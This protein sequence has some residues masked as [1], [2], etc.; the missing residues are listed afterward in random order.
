MNELEKHRIN[1]DA[2]R[3]TTT[4]R[5]LVPSHN[6]IRRYASAM[7]YR[8]RRRQADSPRR[9]RAGTKSSTGQQ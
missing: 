4:S 9:E 8:A 1:T 7:L 5:R 6:A 3:S 2:A